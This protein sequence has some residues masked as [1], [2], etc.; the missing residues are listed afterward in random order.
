MELV[1]H[2]VFIDPD[3]CK[4]S[5][6]RTGVHLLVHFIKNYDKFEFIFCCL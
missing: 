1:S 3:K 2:C 4:N 5:P 6:L